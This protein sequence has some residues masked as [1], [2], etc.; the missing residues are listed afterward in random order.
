MYYSYDGEGMIV[1]DVFG[2]IFD[3]LSECTMTL[4]VLMLANGW[5]TRFKTYDFDDGMETYAPLFLLTIMMHVLFGALSYIDQDAQHKY[6]DFQGWVGYILICTKLTLIAVF[7]Y[8]YS[9]SV[10]RIQKDSKQFY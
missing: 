10:D 1:F 2:T 9:Y 8:F 7:F 4:V 6:H 5:Y 3:L